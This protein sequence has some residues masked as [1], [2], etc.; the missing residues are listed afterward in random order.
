[1]KM[2]VLVTARFVLL[3]VVSSG[4]QEVAPTPGGEQPQVQARL[5]QAGAPIP[6]MANAWTWKSFDVEHRDWIRRRVVEPALAVL[7]PGP[8]RTAAAGFLPD[9]TAWWF[10]ADDRKLDPGGL[11]LRGQAA[12]A[13]GAVDPLTR[14]LVSWLG[15][16]VDHDWR[17]VVNSNKTTLDE[18]ADVPAAGRLVALNLNRIYAQAMMGDKQKQM[19]EAAA[20]FTGAALAAGLYDGDD[21]RF[22]PLQVQLDEAQA[23]RN[24]PDLLEPV[25]AGAKL[26]EWAR[27][28]LLGLVESGYAHTNL[29]LLPN[30]EFT[31]ELASN[32]LRHAEAA[33]RLLQRSWELEPRSPVAATEMIGIVNKLG[34]DEAGQMR[35]WFDRAVSAHFDYMR[36]Y[37]K[38][39]WNLPARE[40]ANQP[41]LLRF[42]TACRE[43]RRYETQVPV[44][45]FEIINAICS[46]L[47]NWRDLYNN[48]AFIREVMDLNRSLLTEPSRASE[49]PA[50][51]S[52]VV[53]D[54]WLCG[55]MPEARAALE[56]LDW[57]LDPAIDPKLRLYKVDREAMLA[58]IILYEHP[59]ESNLILAVDAAQAGRVDEARKWLLQALATQPEKPVR[60]LI[61]RRL[62]ALR[63]DE[64]LESG[65]WVSITPHG[66]LKGWSI[67]TGSWSA[68]PE[69][70][71]V[72]Q[73]DD[74]DAMILLDRDPGTRYEVR[75]KFRVHARSRCCEGG[76]VMVGFRDEV[77]NAE[78]AQW[79]TCEFVRRGR[80]PCLASVHPA[81]VQGDPRY[82]RKRPELRE[83][84]TFLVRVVDGRIT[85][86]V[87]DLLVREN[88]Q[89]PVVNFLTPGTRIGFGAR[90]FCKENTTTFYDL[91][92]RSLADEAV[93]VAAASP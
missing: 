67:R 59:L 63:M 40:T 30:G 12:Q 90:R 1:M 53:L 7:P 28:A 11:L 84:N 61:E 75:G 37:Q 91:E 65:S 43:T 45:Y 87:N 31:A 76:S 32:S 26:P 64:K 78:G 18:L 27:C 20:R 41:V 62:Q 17:R 86:T 25:L 52:F 68:A 57:Q 60:Q 71:L 70:G 79:A 42:A 69:G 21:A 56:R 49:I 89:L 33:A 74:R 34:G 23:Y 3:L 51:L 83:E 85:Y 10:Q 54:A 36:A 38:Y 6:Q 29:H 9:A 80:G 48:P 66:E 92:M 5:E 82:P 58:D 50:R 88:E 47:E 77:G 46:H 19:Y 93:P 8:G 13:A 73:G 72:N 39:C 24:R 22:L 14:F 44:F 4:A 16:K 55:E 2:P 35:L 15:H 81:F